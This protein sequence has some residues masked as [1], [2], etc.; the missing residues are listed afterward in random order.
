MQLSHLLLLANDGGFLIKLKWMR[1]GLFWFG[2]PEHIK[3]AEG[4]L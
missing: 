2:Y 1:F 3:E 4:G